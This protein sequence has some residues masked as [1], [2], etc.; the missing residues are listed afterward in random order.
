MK[1]KTYMRV[2]VCPKCDHAAWEY[3]S[4]GVVKCIWC[5]KKQRRLDAYPDIEKRDVNGKT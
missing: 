4:F 5:K 3:S 1:I 2:G